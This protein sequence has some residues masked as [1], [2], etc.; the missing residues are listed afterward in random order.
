MIQLQKS[1]STSKINFKNQLQKST[2]KVNFKSQLQLQKSTST[3]KV[4]FNFKNQFYNYEL[5]LLI[6]IFDA[7]AINSS[8]SIKRNDLNSWFPSFM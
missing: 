2:S 7:I 8:T 6:I 1:T 4:N 5:L 3:S